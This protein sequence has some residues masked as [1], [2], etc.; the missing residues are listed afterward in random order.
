MKPNFIFIHCTGGDPE[1]TFYPWLKKELESKGY[2]VTIPKFPTPQ[3][4]NLDNWM[5]TFEPYLNNIDDN[6]IFIGRSIGPAFILRIIEQINI[7]IKAAFLICGFASDLN[8]DEF[9]PLVDSFIEKPFD[10]EKIKANCDNFSIYNSDN[11][12]YIPLEKGKELA[13]KLGSDLTIIEGAEHFWFER[14]D[15]L[16][17]DIKSLI[18]DDDVS[19]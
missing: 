5:K 18:K 15:R 1:E 16:L 11:D 3:G 8:L 2:K 6:T 14:F 12:P 4:Q 9:K 19:V 17:E 7:K 13:Q 10:W